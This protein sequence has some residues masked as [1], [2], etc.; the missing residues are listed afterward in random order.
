M[1]ASQST[2]APE[3]FLF[4]AKRTVSSDTLPPYY[5]VYFLFVELLGYKNLGQSEK[6]AW[7]VPLDYKGRA[8][9]IEHRKFGLGI[10]TTDTEDDRAAAA[11][12]A[13]RIRKAVKLAEP[14]F[15]WRAEEAAKQ[16]HLNVRN[17][18]ASLF[19]R[20]EFF[21][22]QYAEKRSEA[23]RR[24]DEKI[25]TDFRS[26][27]S[28]RYPSHE[29]RRESK[30]F[31]LAAIESFFSWTEH[32]FILIAILQGKATTGEEVSQLA[33]AE[34]AT[35]FR[36]ALDIADPESKRFYDELKIIRVQLRNVVAHGAFGKDGEA[37]QFHSGAGAVPML[38]PHN[39]KR[40]YKFGRGVTYVDHVAID[41]INAFVS[42]VWSGPREPARIYIQEQ[43]LPLILTMASSGKYAAAME[44]VADMDQ[45]TAYLSELMDRSAN[46]DF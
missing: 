17:H 42:H 8:I 23:E 36:A 10:F 44:S 22:K 28:I 11:E 24:K 2:K 46:M 27:Y 20:Y 39:E 26:G 35:K 37:F 34:W 7:S 43:S 45:F 32:V 30:W 41:L 33:E 21:V 19:E 13:R 38:L 29:L 31:A 25:R 3:D 9:L 18:A 6:V 15:E 5:L 4:T 12:I 1:P 16:S 14:Y 40:R